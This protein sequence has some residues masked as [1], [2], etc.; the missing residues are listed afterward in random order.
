MSGT[1]LRLIPGVLTIAI[2]T[3]LAITQTGTAITTDLSARAQSALDPSAK[4]WANISVDGRTLV[5]ANSPEL[6]DRIVA[7]LNSA[8]AAGAAVILPAGAWGPLLLSFQVAA[9]GTLAARE[10]RAGNHLDGSPPGE[11][12]RLISFTS[13]CH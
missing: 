10:L 9:L 8:P 5:I 3:V 2:G 12:H 1:F 6:M 7:R 13:D 11:P 4:S